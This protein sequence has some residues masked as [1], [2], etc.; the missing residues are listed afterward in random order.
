MF[1][2]V[3]NDDRK[4]CKYRRSTLGTARSQKFLIVYY[5]YDNFLF[6]ILNLNV[7]LYSFVY[8]CRYS[9]IIT[10]RP[11]RYF[12]SFILVSDDSDRVLFSL[13]IYEHF[14]E[15]FVWHDT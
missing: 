3:C 15:F 9:I 4:S 2:R 7:I 5:V 6:R 8:I 1:V 12:A 14:F 11:K 13:N 10:V